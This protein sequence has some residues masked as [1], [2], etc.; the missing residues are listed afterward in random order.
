MVQ[1]TLS[2]TLRLFSSVTFT[3]QDK[4]SQQ[5]DDGQR[6]TPSGGMLFLGCLDFAASGWHT[7]HC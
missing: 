7:P 6:L 3:Q 5:V 4:G 2:E 1:V